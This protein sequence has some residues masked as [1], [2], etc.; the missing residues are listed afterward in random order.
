[1]WPAILAIRTQALQVGL[2]LLRCGVKLLRSQPVGNRLV[3]RTADLRFERPELAQASLKVRELHLGNLDGGCSCPPIHAT[4]GATDLFAFCGRRVARHKRRRGKQASNPLKPAR[5]PLPQFH[6]GWRF[7]KSAFALGRP[8]PKPP[9]PP[10]ETNVSLH[11]R[12]RRAR[13]S[14]GDW[15]MAGGG[16]GNRNTWWN[17]AEDGFAKHH[18]DPRRLNLSNGS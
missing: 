12:S 1:M 14:S 2:C 10:R 5:K 9:R 15:P 17:T 4:L 7:E 13:R 3:L 11:V 18:P 16:A 8:R 6:K